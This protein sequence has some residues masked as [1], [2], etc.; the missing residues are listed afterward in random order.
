ML[1]SGCCWWLS[2]IGRDSDAIGE[3]RVRRGRREEVSILLS[4][5]K[6][7]LWSSLSSILL[8]WKIVDRRLDT[9]PHL[10]I[11]AILGAWQLVAAWR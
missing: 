1:E 6:T 3:M 10:L 11:A 8:K 2:V 7:S 9:V 5:G 4:V